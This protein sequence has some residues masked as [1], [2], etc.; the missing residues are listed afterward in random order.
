MS[1][2]LHFIII[3]TLTLTAVTARA[4][5]QSIDPMLVNASAKELIDKGH[6]YADGKNKPDSA[7]ICFRIVIDKLRDLSS[8]EDRLLAE[9][10]YNGLWYIYYFQYHDYAKG[11]EMLNNALRIGRQYNDN[12]ARSLFNLA[13]MYYGVAESG[14]NHE[15][16]LQAF[17][18]F[19]QAFDEAKAVSNKAIL[20]NSMCNMLTLSDKS[21]DLGL[22]HDRMNYLER[23]YAGDSDF[24]V[25]YTSLLYKARQ[26]SRQGRWEQ[27]EDS[28]RRQLDLLERD[29][30]AYYPRYKYIILSNIADVYAHQN[31]STEAL[32]TY[33]Q[34]SAIAEESNMLDAKLEVF[35]AMSDLCRSTGDESGARDFFANYLAVKDSMLNYQQL[36]SAGEFNLIDKMQK[37]D[38]Q[39][40]ASQRRADMITKT[41]IASV[42]A[43]IF[44]SLLLFVVWRSNRKLRR[45]NEY[46]YEQNLQLLREDPAPTAI[47]DS[48]PTDSPAP[49]DTPAGK[50]QGSTL[51]DET[52][53]ALAEKILEVMKSSPEIYTI[54]FSI[55]TL[56]DMAG[57]KSKY[58]SQVVNETFGCNFNVLLN[59]YRINEACRRL[60]DF[61]NYGQFTIAAIAE[62]VGFRSVSGFRSAFVSNT[63]LTPS[64]YQHLARQKAAGKSANA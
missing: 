20:Y 36:V 3:V 1:K 47:T 13:C 45:K 41:L 54:G 53:K 29:S 60:N 8:T 55:A 6:E 48:S 38:E 42:V 24:I 50:Y 37:V 40:H 27:A 12:R 39:L 59:R 14:N 64:E 25:V 33:R 26:A 28:Y 49:E 22:L 15:M 30:T 31:R 56:A 43:I 4:A 63:G 62:G 18:A 61:E 2:F 17:R 32:A 9:E 57:S 51:D 52:K 16:M 35:K 44:V 11:Y 19:V 34:A 10:A 7:L 46:I 58:V 23:T 21:G 5:S